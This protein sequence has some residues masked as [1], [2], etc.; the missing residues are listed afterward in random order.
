MA[1]AAARGEGPPVDVSEMAAAHDALINVILEEEEEV[2]AAHRAQ[3]ESTMELV[4]REMSLLAEVDKPGSAIDV[5]V[6]RLAEV[7]ERKA[8]SIAALRERVAAFQTHL[9]EEEVLSK[10]VGLH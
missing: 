2:I 7:L 6:E 8:A 3:I 10:T 5:Y 1:T 9:R 4:K